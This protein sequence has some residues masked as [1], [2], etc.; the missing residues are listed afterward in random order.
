MKELA[1][2][3]IGLLLVAIIG[4]WYISTKNT[5]IAMDE[6]CVS[7]EKEIDNQLQRRYDMIPNY[8]E[9]VKKYAKIEEGVFTAFADARK[10]MA[11]ATT[12]A[13][14]S[15]CSQQMESAVARLMAVAESYP[16]LKS[17][18]NFLKFQDEF[19]GTE[20]RLAVARKNYNDAVE[21]YN[22]RIRQFP[23]SLMHMNPR[24]YFENPIPKAELNKAPDMKSILND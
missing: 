9:I 18:E 12:I 10:A 7:K 6:A 21:R 4:F 24:D 1:I 22:R 17:N 15:A 3:G 13:E 16:A 8:A 14:K 11:N 19:A 20:N 2:A 5:I 23:G